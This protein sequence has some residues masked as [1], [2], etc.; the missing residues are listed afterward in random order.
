MQP[1]EIVGG[2]LAGLG[3]GI[4]LRQHKVPVTIHEAGK[5]PRHRVCGEFITSL[6]A[7]TRE[8][9]GLADILSSARTARR[10]TWS[11]DNSADIEHTLPYPATCL[12]RHRLDEA[13]AEKFVDLGGILLTGSRLECADQ[14][15]RVHACGRKPDTSSRWVGVK[16]HFRKL[17]TRNDLEIHFGRGGYIGLTKVENDAV[18]VCGLLRRGGVDLTQPLASIAREADMK[19]LA[20]R[21]AEAQPVDGSFCAVAGLGYEMKPKD[22]LLHVGD[23]IGLIPPFTGNGMTIAWQSAAVAAPRLV[24]WS[25]G[26]IDWNSAKR[27]AIRAQQRRFGPR[28]RTAR[29]LHPFVLDKKARAA[30]RLLHRFGLLPVGLLYRLMH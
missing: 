27:A 29:A 28:V 9:L 14:P 8:Q 7:T 6:D 4:L 20:H 26:D 22:D 10:V 21:L 2:G 1:V 19:Q 5:Y 18:N 13:L 16:Q 24:D 12:S 15:G 11:E 25:R 30:A 23:R 17:E 3:L